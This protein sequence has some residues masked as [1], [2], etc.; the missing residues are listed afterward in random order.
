[1]RLKEFDLDLSGQADQVQVPNWT[2]ISLNPV[3]GVWMSCSGL[4]LNTCMLNIYHV[5]NK[6]PLNPH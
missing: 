6:F 3:H 2:L 4:D 1:M 5:I